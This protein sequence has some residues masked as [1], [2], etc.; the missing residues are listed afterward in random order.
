[1]AISELQ[2]F[3]I[4]TGTIEDSELLSQLGRESFYEAFGEQNSP[5]DMQAYLVTAFPVEKISTELSEPQIL[6]RII[7][8]ND[9]PAGYSKLLF[10]K[11]H[12]SIGP[13]KA[14]RLQRIYV[15]RKFYGT[16]AGARLLED[17]VQISVQNKFQILWLAVWQE[18]HRAIRF[19]RKF[20]FSVCG[21]EK[22]IIG[23]KVD[24]DYVMKLALNG[25]SSED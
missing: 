11:S 25:F 7:F 17:A 6:Y 3:S 2:A 1:M 9:K 16:G 5:E 20:G 15:L 12:E 13:G 4:R 14:I 22:F 21:T 23:S 10:N 24:D 19:Y 8:S 18:N